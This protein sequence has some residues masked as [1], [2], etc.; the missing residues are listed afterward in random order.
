[1]VQP[2]LV[3]VGS[4]NRLILERNLLESGVF[5]RQFQAPYSIIIIFNRLRPD[6]SDRPAHHGISNA[7]TKLFFRLHANIAQNLADQF[8]ELKSPSEDSVVCKLWLLR[9]DLSD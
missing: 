3:I 7:R 5:E 1:M 8:L 4:C 9:N 2:R 6:K